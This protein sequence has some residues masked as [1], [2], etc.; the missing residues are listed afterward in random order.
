[1]YGRHLKITGNCIR[2]NIETRLMIKMRTYLPKKKSA[3]RAMKM[4]GR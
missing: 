1:M 4:T 3:M 2:R